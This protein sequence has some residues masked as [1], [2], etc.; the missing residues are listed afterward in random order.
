VD[1]FGVKYWSK[2]DA[3]HLCHAIGSHFK[4][5]VDI[6]GKNYCSLSLDWN[7][8]LGYVD[9][10]M[11][12]YVP[13]TLKKLQY[14]PK[15]SPQY[16]LHKHIPLQYGNKKQNVNQDTSKKLTKPE[17]K[18]IQ[19]IVGSFLYYARAIDHTL[20]PAINETSSTQAN[21]MKLTK[22]ECQQILDYTATYPNV[23][24][25]FYASDMVLHVDTDAA[26]LVML[27]AKS[28]IAGY[29]YLSDH[30]KRTPHPNLNRALL[31]EC[32]TL[33]HVVSSAAEAETAGVFHNAQIAISIRY[34]LE[35]MG[36][37]QPPTPIKTD[38]STA[39]GFVHDNIHQKRSKSWD[40]RYHWLWEKQTKQQFH[41]FWDKGTNNH[42][43]YFTKHHPIKHHIKVRQTHKYVRDRPSN[44]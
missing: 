31:V 18:R 23:F 37:Q 32:K 2:E 15:V 34:L 3:D 8:K 1:D 16:S 6:E 4:Y 5:T 21:P 9:I 35:C 30:P 44:A 26:Y 36:H 12:K 11:P 19:S 41:I 24:I 38:N 25:R 43:D 27:K 39:N 28:R 20:L 7:Y 10:S 42:A 40:M 17:I 14:S 13:A 29:F 33:W 22:D